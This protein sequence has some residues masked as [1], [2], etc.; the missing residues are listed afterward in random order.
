MPSVSKHPSWNNP[1]PVNKSSQ[2][3]QPGHPPVTRSYQRGWADLRPLVI[4][5]G[6]MPQAEG[7]A[8]VEMGNTRVMCVA[9]LEAGVPPFKKGTG[10]G[11]V[12]AEYGMLPR[13]T[14]T[15]MRREASAGKQDGR[16]V[17]IQRLIGRSLRAVVDL[18]AMGEHTITVDCDVLRA[19]GGT[20]TAAITGGWVA[21]AMALGTLQ[22][23]TNLVRSPLLGQVAAVSLGVKDGQVLLDLDYAED[24]TVDV[25]MNVIMTGN[26]DLVEVQGTAEGAPFPRNLLNQMLD[27][28]QDGIQQLLAAQRK[29]LAP[30]A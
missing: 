24:R 15:R 8:L 7:S 13:S 1:V 28:A 11:W 3:S 17:E 21:L 25:D 20:R 27:T 14:S 19:D 5:P 12:T 10:G 18:S 16:T 6:A 26:L 2:P 22:A 29:A 30:G 23:Q 4:T 9:S